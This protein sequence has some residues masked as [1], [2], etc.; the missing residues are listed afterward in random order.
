MVAYKR[1]WLSAAA[2]SG[3]LVAAAQA[4]PPP[5]IAFGRIPAVMDAAISPNGQHVAILGGTLDHR[6]LSIATLDQAALPSLD[7][8]DVETVSLRWV[9][10]DYV[11]ARVAYRQSV[12]L[13]QAYRFERNIAVNL[14]AK[15][16]SRLLD[17]DPMSAY[18]VGQPVLGV[19]GS[20]PQAF[21]AGLAQNGGATGGMDTRLQRKG[22]SGVVLALWR[23]NP[24]NGN[25]QLVERGTNDTQ[26]WEV[27]TTGAP[28]VRLDID[29]INHRFSVFGRAGKN[30]WKPVW[31]GGSFE[32]RRAYLG[33]SEPEDAIYLLQDGKLVKK[34]V[35]DG[36]VE[37]VGTTGSGPSLSLVWDEFKN[38]AAGISTGAERPS[39]EWLDA[40]IGGVA[41]TLGRVFKGQD[42]RVVGWA[43][44][45][46]RVLV[47]AG[48]P[49]SPGGWYLFDRGR[50]E[51]SP[52]GEEY[53]E[54]KGVPMGTTKWMVYKSRDGLEIPAYYTRPPGA[55]PGSK[56]P[57]IVLPH[58]GPTSRDTFDFDFI[59]QFLASRGYAVL[60]PQFRGSWGFGQA[61]EDAGA[62]EWGGKMQTD[63]LD[64]V[65]ALAASGEAD[66][67]R[68]C[69]V[70]ASFGGY[71]ALAGAALYPDAYK[72]AASI[73]GIGD[74]GL[75]LVEEGRTYGREA[76]A[77]DELREQLGSASKDKLVAHSPARHAD[78]VKIPVLLI[79][80]DKDTVVPV[81][82]S[83]FM[84]KQLRAAGKPVEL[85]VLAGENHY[86]TQT[87]N[88][89]KV[90]ESLEAFL[91]KNLPAN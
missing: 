34:K 29:E 66:A 27:D 42:V 67:G 62:G 36:A 8:G 35:A 4:A 16:V 84:E 28:R 74:L 71:S 37:P 81:E 85:I 15:W 59:T 78:A 58:G 6:I 33:W 83:Q 23:V 54:L 76:A 3:F 31:Q 50:K 21:V 40:E 24:A 77:I 14:E 49:S 69:I 72:C 80:G 25:G 10:D 75:L 19:T 26:S 60:Q 39:V 63:L 32:S 46:S 47:R 41:T 86:L 73:A 79:H 1:L 56:P 22:E 51:L 17:N 55:A 61:F 45:R 82:Q 9:G 11:L 13:R 65:A 43:K 57:L 90:L 68:V 12:A 70:G 30:G 2:V 89:T 91:A 5:A 18:L 7:L 48:S 52:V 87:A 53:P 64:G 38:T 44:D 88:R 20:P